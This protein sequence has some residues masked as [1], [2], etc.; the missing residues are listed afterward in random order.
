MRRL[1]FLDLEGNVISMYRLEQEDPNRFVYTVSDIVPPIGSYYIRVSG[2]DKYGY[3]FQRITPTT[4]EA[5]TP[6]KV[7]PL[8][9]RFRQIFLFYFVI[10]YFG[11][12][13]FVISEKLFE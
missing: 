3:E 9:A 5:L 6:G 8:G 1:D 4:I 13:K 10:V 11:N 7:V 2:V 12:N